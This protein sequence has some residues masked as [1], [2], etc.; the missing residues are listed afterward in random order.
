MSIR[1]KV[2]YETEDELKKVLQ[3]LDPVLKG[4]TKAAK[5]SGKY[6]RAYIELHSG[7]SENVSKC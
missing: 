5:K 1:I 3:L 6:F 2:S 7:N 4:W